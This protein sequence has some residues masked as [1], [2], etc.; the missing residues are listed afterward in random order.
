MKRLKNS[1]NL[2]KLMKLVFNWTL[3]FV[4]LFIIKIIKSGSPQMKLFSKHYCLLIV[5]VK[6]LKDSFVKIQNFYR[7]WIFN[8]IN[9][10]LNDGCY[11]R[12]NLVL[13]AIFFSVLLETKY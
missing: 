13:D 5:R 2:V 10:T 9:K 8:F 4:I 3:V 6:K 11:C 1:S 7:L 12:N